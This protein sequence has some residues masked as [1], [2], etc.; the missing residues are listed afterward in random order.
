MHVRSWTYRSKD[1]VFQ[2]MPV[3]GQD[4][5]HKEL[6]GFKMHWLLLRALVVFLA[7]GSGAGIAIGNKR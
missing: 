4:S 5:K 6:T 3:F 7:I 1:F 2:N